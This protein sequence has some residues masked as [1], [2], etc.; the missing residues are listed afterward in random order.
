MKIHTR[1]ARQIVLITLA[2]GPVLIP[3]QARADWS[4]SG[5][6]V[7]AL[8]GGDVKIAPDGAG[9]AFIAW[10]DARTSQGGHGGVSYYQV[11]LQ[12][13]TSTGSI[14]PGW[15]PNGNL[16]SS[17]TASNYSVS[18]LVP[19]G[20]GGVLVAWAGTNAG[21][22]GIFGSRVL[23]DGQVHPA[24][25]PTGYKACCTNPA[26]TNNPRLAADG[27][28]GAFLAWTQQ[29]PE[30]AFAR[31]VFVQHLTPLGALAAGWQTDGIRMV[32]GPAFQSDHHVLPAPGGGLYLT[33]VAADGG[34]LKRVTPS[35]TIEGGWPAQ[36]LRVFNG[37]VGFLNL[38]PDGQ[39][40][41]VISAVTNPAAA[42]VVSTR[43]VSPGAQLEAAAVLGT[44][45][46]YC[47]RR[48]V[49][50]TYDQAH[51]AL[52]A[53]L[54]ER[55]GQQVYAGRTLLGPPA[56]VAPGWTSTGVRVSTTPGNQSYI[57]FPGL[58]PD[59]DGGAFIAL[60]SY[61]GSVSGV[62]IQHVRADGSI[63]PT[64]GPEGKPALPTPADRWEP[65]ITAV[66]PGQA[67]VVWHETNSG[68]FAQRITTDGGPVPTVLSLVEADVQ[69]GRV[70]LRWQASDAAA[71]R[72][73]VE[74]S[75]D[76][77]DWMTLGQ[78]RLEGTALLVYDDEAVPPGR[79]AYRLR[80]VQDSAVRFSALTWVDVPALSGLALGG[81]QPNPAIGAA[82]ITFSLP[83]ARPAKLL[84]QDVAGR[85]VFSR[86]VGDL[87][88]GTHVVRMDTSPVLASGIYW[89]RLVG[90]E[91]SFAAKGIVIR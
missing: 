63:D 55:S 91:G 39:D 73:S 90:A 57:K 17:P 36:G 42:C 15:L 87:G 30:P 80:Y 23:P 88:P 29:Q 3:V 59:G 64:W 60:D 14:A 53:W 22:R 79:F 25:P 43:R 40:G 6:Q 28:G 49:V 78:P 65:A 37:E 83:D 24:W 7:T 81:F 48:M 46:Q 89:I 58:A 45:T 68:L 31:D 18:D 38:Q 74:R 27:S 77:E 69:P 56:S 9:G 71:L 2:T 33:W 76:G 66:G 70:S 19:D 50:S 47:S 85:V 26:F 54:D 34:Y 72:A 8:G 51:G 20:F 32:Q 35:G 84:V 10:T 11:Y 16:V 62:W 61:V 82:A 52:H 86:E 4:P 13:L 44:T 1:L 75:V 41:A 21:V 12:H 67:I 5:V